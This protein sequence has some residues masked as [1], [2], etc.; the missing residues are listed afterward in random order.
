MYVYYIYLILVF[1]EKILYGFYLIWQFLMV[2]ERVNS[3]CGHK[4]TLAI[5]LAWILWKTLTITLIFILFAF[6]MQT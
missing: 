4:T 2:F 1:S 6:K 3:V 5:L